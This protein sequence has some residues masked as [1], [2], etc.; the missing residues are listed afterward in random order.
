M[1]IVVSLQ[2]KGTSLFV[3]QHLLRDELIVR[4]IELVCN[5]TENS[6]VSKLTSSKE[7]FGGGSNFGVKR[8]RK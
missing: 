3:I 6:M 5:Y 4:A 8:I 2:L 7:S 1:L